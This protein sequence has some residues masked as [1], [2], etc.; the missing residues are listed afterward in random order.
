MTQTIF[1]E[2]VA[3][4]EQDI[5]AHTIEAT[6]SDEPPS[7]KLTRLKNTPT[8][9]ILMAVLSIQR[10]VL[11][12]EV[13]IIAEEDLPLPAIPILSTRLNPRPARNMLI[14]LMAVI[15]AIEIEKFIELI[16][17]KMIKKTSKN[18]SS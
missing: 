6:P 14:S 16:S 18:K 12:I 3:K 13:G 17:P 10:M 11:V 4:M 1:P 2:E 9:A 7:S 8:I 5:E 15:I